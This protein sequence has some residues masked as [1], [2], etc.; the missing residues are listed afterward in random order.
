[1]DF[2]QIVENTTV[3]KK[4]RANSEIPSESKD[5]LEIYPDFIV[6]RSKDL[7]IRG[8]SFYAIWDAEKNMWS[9]D[10]YDV[11]RLV[12]DSL[13]EH[14]NKCKKTFD[15]TIRLK[16][17]SNF[18]SKMW[19][20]YRTCINQ[21]P[22]SSHQLDEELTFMNTKIKKTS[23]I[24]RILPY[25]LEEGLITGYNELMSTLYDPEEREKLEWA[26][27]SI[28]AGDSKNI[29]KFI[30]LY[31][32]MGS[33]KSTFLNIVQKLFEGYYITFDAKALTSS[34]N[35][36]STEAFKSNPLIAIQHD[37]DLSKIEDNTK[38][39]SIV[40]HEYMAMRE[41]YKPSYTSRINAFLFMGTN[42]PVKI[43]DAKSGIIR[44][45]ID[46]H[47]SG[48]KVPTRRYHSLMT[49][50]DFELGAIAH[51]CLQ[52]YMGM[53]MNYY[54]SYR[55]IDMMLQTDVF[56]NFVEANYYIFKEQDEITLSQAYE[57]YKT[58]CDESLVDFKM[59]RHKFREELKSYFKAFKDY[60]RVDGRTARSCYSGFLSD[61]FTQIVPETKDV[62]KPSALVL[63]N[64]SS[65]LDAMLADCPA[66]YATIA[67]IPEKKWDDV[68]TKLS[69]IN[70]KE[71]HYVKVP[72][73]HI[74]ID[75]DLRD[76]NGKKSLE[77]NIEAASTWPATYAEFSKSGAGVHLHYIYDGPVTK[78]SRVYAD[79]IEVKVFTG[80]SSLRRKLTKCNN[81]P[82]AI[83]NSGLPLKGEK[84]VIDF[85][86][87]MN[88]QTIRNQILSNLRKEVHP[89][90]KSSVDFI[91][92]IL[93]D[94]Y[95]SGIHYDVSDMRQKVLNFAMNS[96]NQADRCIKLVGEMKFGSEDASPNNET[97]YDN[98]EVVFYDVEVFPN[99]FIVVWKAEGSDKTA[100]KMINPTPQE[101]EDL[102]KLRLVGFNCRRYDNHILYARYIGKNNAELY[103]LSQKIVNN[104]RSAL[105]GEAY[106]ISYTDVFDFSS[107][108]QSLKK[109]Q[110]DLKIHHRE[111]GLPWD[112]PVPEERWQEVADYCVNDVVATE[113]VFND[114]KQDFA[115]RQILA[116]LS[117]LTVNDTTQTHAAK[118]LFGD[119]KKPQDKF[120]YTDLSESFPGYVFEAGKS[121]YRSDNPSE[122]GYVYSEPGMYQNVAVLDI[123]SMHP[124]SLIRMNMFGPYTTRFEDLVRA[125][126]AIKHNDVNKLEQILDGQLYRFLTRDNKPIDTNVL[127]DLAYSLKI[128]INSIYGYTSASFENKFRDPRNKDNIVAKRGALFMIE[129]KHAVQEKGWTVAHIKTDS[130]KIPD[131]TKEM[132]DF[133]VEFGERY[134]YMF[135]HEDTYERF[136]LV[137]D[138]VYIALS[139][140]E[141]K[142]PWGTKSKWTG[143]G[144]Q[145]NPA[146]NPY[147]F[148][149]LFTH[150]PVVFDDMCES[151]TVTTALYLDMN[152]GLS[153]DEHNY[154]F[155]GKAGSFTP[156]LPG[157]GGGMLCREK[158]GKYYAATGSKGF[159]WLEAELVKE[160]GKEGD[161]DERYYQELVDNAVID[162][163]KYGDFE[164]FI[165]GI[166]NPIG[167]NDM[168]PWCSNE[169]QDSC[170][171]CSQSRDCST[172]KGT[173]VCNRKYED[174]CEKCRK[175]ADEYAAANIA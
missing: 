164:W 168:P 172:D 86:N 147:V 46:V 169:D 14:R 64:R 11:Q 125:R 97:N 65:I 135:E 49:M 122:G 157:C 29:Q 16:K 2:Y 127:K 158:D 24:S 51:H 3:S 15:G 165:D 137:N 102:F 163:S 142:T 115:A 57:M 123:A 39:N 116:E 5:V 128:V 95:K 134:G 92:K 81:V 88:E 108:K 19:T 98:D 26:I 148:K 113:A 174:K 6:R 96:T 8:R 27:G 21:M 1:M 4:G 89:G 143:T 103:E 111:L 126:L 77:L 13:E 175:E 17:L 7:M 12:D 36:F 117:G 140:Q 53:G 119:D 129:L 82:V 152:E 91:Y 44:R 52:V 145:F 170:S 38:L 171:G 90:T 131:A 32:E 138:A 50:I 120:I 61:K 28:I 73:N 56:F 101:I 160:I 99:L 37:G 144:T 47:P 94:A 63:N 55:P 124:W 85:K 136:C 132:I 35:P 159:R 133:V 42:K 80:K 107:I 141:H 20:N 154:H 30:V 23:Y 72:S 84:P 149:K 62:S 68:K 10:E 43:T 70:T 75:F 146:T 78:L 110:L 25:S 155:V 74:V 100:V 150:D 60:S 112:Q 173:H 58:Y 66:Q 31:G 105:Y 151:K 71:V 67:E 139:N 41:L 33:G 161:V 118:I 69:D 48:R 93:D 59:P 130:I 9:T 76:K 22:D 34:S 109:F 166:D 114:R 162:I 54:S 121:S 18:S 87:V 167:I 45:L 79:G 156:I 83:I 40:S 106:N 104:N 153:E